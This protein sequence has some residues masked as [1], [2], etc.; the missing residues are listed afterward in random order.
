MIAAAIERFFRDK[1][2]LLELS[3]MRPPCLFESPTTG[4][5]GLRLVALGALLAAWPFL[6]G[7]GR[8]STTEAAGTVSVSSLAGD[9]ESARQTV[10]AQSAAPADP[11]VASAA[12]AG[13]DDEYRKLIVGKWQQDNSEKRTITVKADGTATIVAELSDVRQYIVGKILRFDL[14]WTIEEGTL[15]FVTLGG[16]PPDSIKYINAIYG[17]TRAYRI[18]E[19]SRERLLPEKVATGEIEPEW[20]RLADDATH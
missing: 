20:T 8:Q 6:A 2:Y 19:F 16:D 9:E 7:C 5:S 10:P 13:D 1:R 18:R 4:L 12:P 15:T 3:T 17:K 11:K 14:E